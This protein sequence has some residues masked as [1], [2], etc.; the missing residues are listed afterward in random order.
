VDGLQGDEA[1]SIRLDDNDL[2]I[3]CLSTN[4]WVYSIKT[5]VTHAFR[6]LR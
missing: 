1:V 5:P 4:R 6:Y 3:E 2:L